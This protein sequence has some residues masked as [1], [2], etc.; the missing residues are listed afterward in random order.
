MSADG[1]IGRA[2]AYWVTADTIAWNPG[3]WNPGA[4]RQAGACVL[5]S[6][7]GTAIP[8]AW[9]PAG[10]PAAVREKLP[11]LAGF[12]AFHLP[13]DRLAEVPAALKG[14]LAVE[15]R[16]A[17][18]ALVD[19]TGLQIQGVLDDLYTYDGPL[20]AH[21]RR[22]PRLPTLRVW[23]PTARAVQLHLFADSNPATAATVH[24]MTADPAT[25]VWSV[26]GRRELVRQV[27][28]LRGRTSSSAP[29]AGSRPTWSPIPTR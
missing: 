18:G 3:A 8:L 27:L 2:Q 24:A 13:A 21:L 22:R 14:P 16:D 19:A 1:N 15:A 5:S 9:D 23:A 11:H 7:A 17:A 25:G 20:G 29:R 4:G 10:L 26:T 28:P 12:P 6:T